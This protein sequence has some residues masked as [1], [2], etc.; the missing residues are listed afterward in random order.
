MS[1]LAFDM[2]GSSIKYA[3]WDDGLKA[4][5]SFKT[6][7]TWDEMKT[8]L[9]SVFDSFKDDYELEGVAFSAP[10]SVNTETGVIGGLS[11]I[12]YIHHFN[13]QE[14][15]ESL[16]KLSVSLENDANCAALAEVWQGKAK[17]I[18]NALFVV[19][20]TGIGGAVIQDRKLVK[21]K[22]LYGGEFGLMMLNDTLS[23]SLGATA[24]NMARRYAKRNNLPQDSVSGE[25]VFTLA[26]KGDKIAL[27][28]EENFYN[29]LAQGIY[30]IMF[31]TDPERI[32]LG[33]GVTQYEPLI[34][35]LK[36]RLDARIEKVGLKD[37]AYDLTA[38][39]FLNDANLVG[40]VYHFTL[41]NE[42]T[43]T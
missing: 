29:Y 1:I 21:G 36:K 19:I 10:G 24:V 7:K 30:N 12:P 20:G 37:Y 2:G 28:E 27:E 4:Q 32:I 5:S 17:D 9:L 35:N 38:C 42:R 15:L 34:P 6:P 16:F 31:T 23:F 11:A 33:G 8:H 22:N 43:K 25:E 18:N 39:A 41:Q 40:A 13:I 26:R 14:E 3:I